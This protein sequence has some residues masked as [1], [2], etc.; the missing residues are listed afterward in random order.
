MASVKQLKKNPATVPS[1]KAESVSGGDVPSTKVGGSDG[2]SRG[3]GGSS[4][5]GSV[6]GGGSSPYSDASKPSNNGGKTRK[7]SQWS[8]L[9]KKLNIRNGATVIG[10]SGGIKGTLSLG[11]PLLIRTTSKKSFLTNTS[12]NNNS[13][14]SVRIENTYQ[15]GPDREHTFRPLCVQHEVERLLDQIL[16]NERYDS[17][18]SGFLT[19]R[20]AEAVKDR[21]KTLGFVR[22]KLV[23]QTMLSSA[24]GQSF[25][26]ASRCLW[27]AD[28][29]NYTTAVY[30]NPTLF[31]IVSVYGLYYE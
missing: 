12:N 9:K 14:E 24:G 1:D 21:V 8:L 5:N 17:S 23:V 22:H 28:T 20:I 10:G 6:V 4:D 27:N 26:I 13:V 31:A 18:R 30:Q 15:L 7:L 2:G 16:G 11:N 3:G 19:V 25:E 29:D